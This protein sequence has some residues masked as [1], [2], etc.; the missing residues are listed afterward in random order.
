MQGEVLNKKSCESL[1]Q[2]AQ[3]DCGCFVPG[4]PDRV[5]SDTGQPGLVPDLEVGVPAWGREVGT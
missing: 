1:E 3:K 4:V 5:G 2:A